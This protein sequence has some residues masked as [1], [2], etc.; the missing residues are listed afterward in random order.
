MDGLWKEFGFLWKIDKNWELGVDIDGVLFVWV[1][2]V[3][4]KIIFE[5]FLFFGNILKSLNVF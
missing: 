5:I 2:D 3:K 1:V 4:K